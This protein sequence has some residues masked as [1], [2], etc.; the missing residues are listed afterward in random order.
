M[1]EMLA[2]RSKTLIW[3][4]HRAIDKKAESH[5]VRLQRDDNEKSDSE[6]TE[7][8]TAIGGEETKEAQ[9]N[10]IYY[11]GWRRDSI[12]PVSRDTHNRDTSKNL[13]VYGIL[14]GYP[15]SVTD[16]N[17]DLKNLKRPEAEARFS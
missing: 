3:I 1:K 6:E 10:K 9:D 11:R 8:G 16:I 17:S 12:H 5:G 13:R 7:E 15:V 2:E 14:W 4:R